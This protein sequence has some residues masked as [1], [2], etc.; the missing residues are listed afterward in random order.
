MQNFEKELSI[1]I[2]SEQSTKNESVL[3]FCNEI[4]GEVLLLFENLIYVLC[5]KA[6]KSLKDLS[7]HQKDIHE[8]VKEGQCHV[9]DKTM[10][11]KNLETH[12]KTHKSTKIESGTGG[13]L[14]FDSQNGYN[15]VWA[16]LDLL[17]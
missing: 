9:C 4:I 7:R 12:L 3:N 1:V 10:L 13:F 5:R 17:V 11:E 2:K 15:R 8:V 6:F 14:L 16:L